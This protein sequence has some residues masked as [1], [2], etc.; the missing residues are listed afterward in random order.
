M[1]N[2]CIFCKIVKK[3][4]PAYVLYEDDEIMVFL[5]INPVSHGHAIYIPKQ[6]YADLFQIPENEMNFIRKLPVIANKLKEV[7]KATGMNLIQNNGVDAGQAISHFHIHLIPRFTN[8]N[9]FKFP[10]QNKLDSEEAEQI[11]KK[12]SEL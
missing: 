7:T 9:L 10:P 4:I 5:D 12:F 2:E 3:E 1:S 6:H 11:V 8:D